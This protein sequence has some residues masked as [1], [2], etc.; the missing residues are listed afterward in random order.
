VFAF[1]SNEPNDSDDPNDSHGPG[2]LRSWRRAF[3]GRRACQAFA[4]SAMTAFGAINAAVSCVGQLLPPDA[5]Q[6]GPVTA[7]S[8]AL[9]VAWGLARARPPSAVRQEFRRP[10]MTVVV[11][12]GDLFDQRAHLVVGFSDTFDT[13]SADGVVINS[14]SVQ[15]QL[16][17]R[18]YDGAVRRLDAELD[19]ALGSVTPVT[20][21]DRDRKPIGKLDRYPIGTVAVLGVRP[22]LVFA[23]AYSHLDNQYVAGSNLEDLWFS[24]NRLWDAVHRHA[25]LESVAMPLVGSGLS[26]IDYLDQESLLRLILLSFIARSRSG[27]VCRELRVVVRPADLAKINMAE[28]AAFL[29]T[30]SSGVGHP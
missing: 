29:R 22:Q 26:R 30:L 16:L 10:D 6:P 9:C 28:V 23:S 8:V 4:A 1:L 7:A 14:A 2:E 19:A 24:L 13:A 3:Q 15:G 27:T 11:E 17:L 21:E 12:V 25:Q 5:F 20:R 18:H